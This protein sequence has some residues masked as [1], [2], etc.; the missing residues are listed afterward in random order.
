MIPARRRK[1]NLVLVLCPFSF[2]FSY[3]GSYIAEDFIDDTVI[4]GDKDAPSAPL[5]WRNFADPSREEALG[6]EWQRLLE[7]SHNRH[8]AGDNDQ[9][10]I[11]SLIDKAIRSPLSSDYP[12]W[13]VRCRVSL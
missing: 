10:V 5:T 8:G 13:R 11:S 7:R 1:T 2:S 6:E 3:W 9:E 12:L 4:H